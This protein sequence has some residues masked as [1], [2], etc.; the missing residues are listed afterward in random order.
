MTKI[1]V[2]EPKPTEPQASQS[3]A[4]GLQRSQSIRTSNSKCHFVHTIG[5]WFG[6]KMP[7]QGH[8]TDDAVNIEAL[9]PDISHAISSWA[10]NIILQAKHK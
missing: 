10:A 2:Q 6:P 8:P 9:M 1:L 7:T 5:P 4:Q 3:R